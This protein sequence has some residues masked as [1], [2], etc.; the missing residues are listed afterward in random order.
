MVI[1]ALLFKHSKEFLDLNE[2]GADET[3]MIFGTV[4]ASL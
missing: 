2:A 1:L 3:R 4:A